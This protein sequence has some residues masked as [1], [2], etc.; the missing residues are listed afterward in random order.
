MNKLFHRV[1]EVSKELLLLT[2][3]QRSNILLRIAERAESSMEQLLLA[4]SIDLQKLEKSNPLYDRLLLTPERITSIVADL[5]K[6]ASLPSPLGLVSKERTLSNG[7]Y[8]RRVSVPFGVIGV[9]FEARPNV[10]FDVFSICFKSGN[11]CV[12]KGSHTAEESNR[13]IVALIHDVLRE[14]GVPTDVLALL[15]PTHEATAN[16][17]AAVGYVD[18]CIPRGGK[19]LIEFVR[20]NARVPVIET[21]AGVVHAYF[22]KDGDIEKGRN[23]IS[24]AKMRRVSVCNA[25]DC[26]LVHRERVADI[27]S[28]IE[29]MK[30]KV[31]IITDEATMGT[32][33]MDYKMSLKI[34]NSIDDALAHIARYG[35]G[36][37]ECIITENEATAAHFQKMVDAACVY[38]NAPTSFTDGAQ[39][40][41]GAEIGISTQKLG[42][43]GPM[44]LEEMTTYKWFING[45]GQIRE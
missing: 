29:P 31:D 19:K 10:C 12:L 39:F 11:A 20:D 4:N 41:M 16:L 30:D 34:V 26:L 3:E 44:A 1:K 17:L 7:L 9:I 18:L 25:L 5:R 38:V 35:S 8:L 37:S 2:D 33:W 40:G 28:L 21:G 27:P 42:P 23:I 24:N 32:E 14:T 22:D 13:A 15:P 45:D 6:V 36:H 43:R